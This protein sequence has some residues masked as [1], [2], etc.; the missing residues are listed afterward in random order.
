MITDKSLFTQTLAR[1]YAE[2]GYPREAAR[3]Y[4]HLLETSPD[5]PEYQDAF[6]R[7]ENRLATDGLQADADLTGLI[8][9]WIDLEI[10]YGRMKRFA[11]LRENRNL[12][13]E[14]TDDYEHIDIA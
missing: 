12:Y 11:A 10:G 5:R 3:I 7:I 13:A 6:Q 2:Q 1:V 4:R 8:S 14:K 9:T